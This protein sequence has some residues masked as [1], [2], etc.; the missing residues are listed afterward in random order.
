MTI[1]GSISGT[2]PAT[3]SRSLAPVQY[4]LLALLCLAA[5]LPGIATLPPTDRDE[6]RFVQATKQMVESGDYVDIRF[7][8]QSRYKKPAGIYWLQSASVFLSGQGAEAPI[9]VYRLVSILG[10]TIAVLG[11]GWLGARMFGATAGMIA[12]TALAGILMLGFEARIAKTDATLLAT[13]VIAQAAL[14]HIYLGHRE[15]AAVSRTAPFIFWAAQGAAILI[16]GPVVL[17]VSLLTIA[18][19]WFFDPDRK[20]LR[21][22]RPVSGI[23]LM[24]LIAA[25]WL[26][27]ITWK[28]GAAFW[29]ESLGQDFA[30][31]I[32]SGQ[33]SHGFPPGYYAV[34]FVLFVWP[35][36]PL[37]LQGGLK[38]LN[39]FRDDPALLFC[40]CWYIPYW[41]VIE[42][43]PTKLPHYVLPAYPAL[44]LVLGWGLA[45]P[46]AET[47]G[48][49][50]WQTWLW[51][52]TLAGF[53]AVTVALAA[54]SAGAMP[55]LTGQF[56]LWG[57][58][59]ALFILAAAWFGS[60]L[61]STFPP[62]QSVGLATLSAAAALAVLTIFVVP[63]L[64]PL[65]L[66]PQIAQ[67]FERV[68]TCPDSRLF[69]VGYHEP[70]L[71]FLAG[72][73]TALV[74]APQ[75]AEALMANPQCAIAVIDESAGTA[76]LDALPA[77]TASVTEIGTVEGINYSKGEARILKLYRATK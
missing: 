56:S 32:G 11:T 35:F 14:A 40:L 16:K 47:T 76:F 53:L 9:W 12:G 13:A 77:G 34:I 54:V 63:Q 25:P 20:W 22:L 51:R 36:A 29:Q 62:L 58:I 60:G 69:A 24:L 30:A 73:N 57:V 21:G 5:F 26:I 41:L 37:A 7:Q 71:V 19:L 15:R 18:A 23:A 39:R 61:R 4:L 45:S 68:K 74:S 50:R 1:A 49:K 59:A 33:E 43:V 46:L 65:W 17:G 66:S 28:S 6:S 55:Y 64:K 3:V 2:A 10:G 52:L 8:D 48:L 27:L 42:L 67:A 75:A 70:S 38:A 44:L 31:K 72:T